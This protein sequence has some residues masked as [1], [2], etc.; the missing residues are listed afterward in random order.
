MSSFKLHSQRK[1]ELLQMQNTKW[2]SN[3]LLPYFNSVQ[4]DILASG[5]EPCEVTALCR[6]GTEPESRVGK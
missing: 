1:I 4:S 5:H 2:M 6:S 3:L